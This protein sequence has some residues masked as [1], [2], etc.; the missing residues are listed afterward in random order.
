MNHVSTHGRFA[1]RS[2]GDTVATMPVARKLVGKALRCMIRIVDRPVETIA[3]VRPFADGTRAMRRDCHAGSSGVFRAIG[4][5][6]HRSSH[7]AKEET[8]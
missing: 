4:L 8:K 7:N 6:I 2:E 1:I 5:I 3:T